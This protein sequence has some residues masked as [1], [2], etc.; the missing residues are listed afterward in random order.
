M[1]H[2]DLMLAEIKGVDVRNRILR[3]SKAQA[4]HGIGFIDKVFTLLEHHDA[5]LVARVWIKGLGLPFKL[6]D[7]A[8]PALK[9]GKSTSPKYL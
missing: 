3:G 8:V 2:F 1:K 9:P 6:D 4:R 5:K 7:A